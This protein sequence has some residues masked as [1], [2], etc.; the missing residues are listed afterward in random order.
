M[1]LFPGVYQEKVGVA[2]RKE[3][4]H[5]TAASCCNPPFSE[6]KKKTLER[7]GFSPVTEQLLQVNNNKRTSTITGI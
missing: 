2:K 5:K 3:A 7:D 4:S 6:V 1:F